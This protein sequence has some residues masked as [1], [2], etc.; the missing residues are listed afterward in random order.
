MSTCKNLEIGL[1][2]VRD[3]LNEY[4][5]EETCGFGDYEVK[6]WDSKKQASI[7][8]KITDYASKDVDASVLRSTGL[9]GIKDYIR[10][11]QIIKN[12]ADGNKCVEDL[13]GK[14]NSKMTTVMSKLLNEIRGPICRTHNC[15]N[16]PAEMLYGVPNT[17][18]DA[19]AAKNMDCPGVGV[20]PEAHFHFCGFKDYIKKDKSSRFKP[21][22]CAI[23]VTGYIQVP[24]E[25]IHH[26]CAKGGLTLTPHNCVNPE[27]K[28]DSDYGI[29]AFPF[30]IQVVNEAA[31]DFINA[32]HHSYEM[33]RV[34]QRISAVCACTKDKNGQLL[35]QTKCLHCQYRKTLGLGYCPY[36]HICWNSSTQ[37]MH[38]KK[39][40]C[41]G[42]N[43][44]SSTEE[45]LSSMDAGMLR[46]KLA[47]AD[48]EIK[49]LQANQDS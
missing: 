34:S 35:P 2:V 4:F 13:L 37:E 38:C 10:T 19:D 8:T 29:W 31:L 46:S 48:A 15:P 7:Y 43:D 23:Y 6:P 41:I 24:F 45:D 21:D 36:C 26:G 39:P 49:R 30:E 47:I 22:G 42:K 44:P 1:A 5:T 14:L 27:G 3:I 16:C 18:Y 40:C 20:L 32:N 12:G 33:Q 28:S 9:L 25:V 17:D 11:R